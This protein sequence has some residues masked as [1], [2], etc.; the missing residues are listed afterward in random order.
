MMKTLLRSGVTALALGATLLA[1]NALPAKADAT[2]TRNIILG[3]AA[4][5]GLATAI[6][7]ENKNRLATTI[8]GYLPNGDPV[9]GD[10][11]VVSSNGQ[12]WYPG[13]NNASV[14]CSNGA[15]SI[16]SN[17]GYGYGYNGYNGNGYNGYGSYNANSYNRTYNA[18]NRSDNDANRYN[19]ANRYNNNDANRY[20][21]NDR[22]RHRGGPQ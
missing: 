3:A 1:T 2:S 10:G 20:S 18:Y 9:Y 8:Q 6:N 14:A 16:T 15:C 21:N 12:T 7:V 11:H 5:A 13:N 22:R 17:N 19:V 4:I